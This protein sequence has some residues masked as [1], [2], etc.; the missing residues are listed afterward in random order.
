MATA[1]YRSDTHK[2]AKMKVQTPIDK[3]ASLCHGDDTYGLQDV[4]TFC[5]RGKVLQ[6]G[7]VDNGLAIW[8]TWAVQVR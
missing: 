4:S 1:P 8:S 5:V 7:I 3:V 6:T 2:P